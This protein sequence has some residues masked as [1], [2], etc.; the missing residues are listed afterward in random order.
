MSFGGDMGFRVFLFVRVLCVL[1][2]VF[3][4]GLPLEGRIRGWGLRRVGW[5]L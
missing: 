1:G 2:F 5:S 4:V 3:F